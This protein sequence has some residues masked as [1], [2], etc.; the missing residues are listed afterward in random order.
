M[1]TVEPGAQVTFKASY[2][3][4]Y[5]AGSTAESRK[6][7]AADL[8]WELGKTTVQAAD[9]EAATGERVIFAT[10]GDYYNMQTAQRL[11]Y[12]I[13]EGNQIQTTEYNQEPYFAVLE[14][15]S[16]A[17][18]DAGTDA[19]DVA[20]AISGPFWLLRNGQIQVDA[21]NADLMPR[22]S[23]GIK[24]DGSIVI[25]VADGRQDPYSVGQ[26]LYSMADFL[27]AQGVVDAIYLDG[28]G[29][30]TY[31]S[32]REGSEGLEIRNSPSGRHGA[33]RVQRSAAGLH[34]GIHRGV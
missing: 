27:K 33:R 28:G 1:T 8:A 21:N 20:E 30:A 4:Y 31:V 10:N 15:G 24:A 9:Y 19:S 23:I 7:A 5:T 32:E 29:S 22:N 11:G 12:L 6:E 17:L 18:R 3:G 34:R 26:T 16:Y 25:Y 14:D 13:M 2:A